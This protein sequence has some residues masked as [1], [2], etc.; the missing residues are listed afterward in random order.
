MNLLNIITSPF[1][2]EMTK[3]RPV[4]GIKPRR[5]FQA[6]KLA[7][8]SGFS[9]TDTLFFIAATKKIG[10]IEKKGRRFGTF[11][12]LSHKF[13]HTKMSYPRKGAILS[14]PGRSHRQH[15][16]HNTKYGIAFAFLQEMRRVK[17]TDCSI[18]C[19]LDAKN[20]ALIVVATYSDIL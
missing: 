18:R 15:S 2:G 5:L 16:L 10:G 20:G 7:I 13:Q 8:F 12:L 6:A 19:F 17:K 14:T 9:A 11:P 4:Y 1:P 3:P